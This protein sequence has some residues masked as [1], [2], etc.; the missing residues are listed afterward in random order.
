MLHCW[1]R[2]CPVQVGWWPAEEPPTWAG[3]QNSTEHQSLHS[4]GTPE[5]QLATPATKMK[6][7][8][9]KKR[10]SNLIKNGKHYNTLI[11]LWT[12]STNNLN[13]ILLKIKKLRF[14]KTSLK[15][16]KRILTLNIY[17]IPNGT[18]DECCGASSRAFWMAPSPVTARSAPPAF[19]TKNSVFLK[20]NF[21]SNSLQFK[22]WKWAHIN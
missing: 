22:K 13:K 12:T 7:R 19:W 11:Q 9:L 1:C 3:S 8:N 20:N 16:E 14:K 18:F 2:R 21:H 6:K 5:Y 15:V 4:A 10:K 17:L